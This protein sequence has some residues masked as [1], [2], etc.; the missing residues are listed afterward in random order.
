LD[1]ISFDTGFPVNFRKLREELGEE[2]EII[3]GPNIVLLKN[4]K[5]KEV[6][7]E[8]KKYVKAE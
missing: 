2:I 4:G 6:K 5:E 7:D 8:V 1:V 3:G